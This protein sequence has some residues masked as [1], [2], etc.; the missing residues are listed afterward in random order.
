MAKIASHA[1]KK[2]SFGVWDVLAIA[3]CIVLLPILAVNTTLI[4]KGLASSEAV[5]TFAGYA[6]MIVLSDSMYPHIERGVSVRV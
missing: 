1:K 4:V 3:L 6:P 5:P 2:H